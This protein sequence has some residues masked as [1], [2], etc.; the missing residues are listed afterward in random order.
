MGISVRAFTRK[1]IVAIFA[2]VVLVGAPLVAFDF[3]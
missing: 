1:N 3:C 2:G